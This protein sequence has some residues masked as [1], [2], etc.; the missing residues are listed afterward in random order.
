MQ[1]GGA[2]GTGLG[3]AIAKHLVD[4]ANGS[5]Q[6]VS[7]PTV[8]PGTVC[9]VQ[10]PFDVC[11]A[12][13]VLTNDSLAQKASSEGPITEVIRVLIIDDVRMN[14]VML[15]KR[16][17]KFIAP[18]SII[19]EAKN[20]EDALKIISASAD[21][22][23]VMIVDQFMEESGGV[24]LG[25]ELVEKLRN[26]G[27]KALLIGCSGNE[28]QEQFIS[29]GCQFVWG[30]P[31]PPN[32]ESI[33]QLRRGLAAVLSPGMTW[34]DLAV[35]LGSEGKVTEHELVPTLMEKSKSTYHHS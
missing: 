15:S 22:F 27:V 29:V 23:D 34:K 2:P 30:K 3:L 16:I 35:Q 1:R 18:N 33:G 5:I 7:D 6:F 11:P 31:M 20:G 9:M 24:L 14:R 4:L 26:D 19:T 8:R 17:S 12:P 21:P 13:K 25:T 10:C 32:E 28:I